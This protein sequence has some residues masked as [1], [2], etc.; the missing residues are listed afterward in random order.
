MYVGRSFDRSVGFSE[1]ALVG[2]ARFVVDQCGLLSAFD[3][4]VIGHDPG[5]YPQPKAPEVGTWLPVRMCGVD[6]P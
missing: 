5:V 1:T 2:A 3:P 4:D 6:I